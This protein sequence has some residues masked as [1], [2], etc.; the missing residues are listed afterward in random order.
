MRQRYNNPS[1]LKEILDQMFGPG[2]YRVTI[3]SERYI[4]HLPQPLQAGELDKIEDN[5]RFHYN[6][7]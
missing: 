3:Q 7:N 5:I 1:K 6:P 2:K 4:L